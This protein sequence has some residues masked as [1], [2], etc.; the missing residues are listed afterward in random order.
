MMIHWYSLPPS[1]SFMVGVSFKKLNRSGAAA[2][3]RHAQELCTGVRLDLI[4]DVLPHAAGNGRD[5][6][7]VGPV[8]GDLNDLL[9]R[10]ALVRP[11]GRPNTDERIGIQV[12]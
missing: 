9:D 2:L 6:N 7:R 3:E 12:S 11:I 5:A 4:K 1:A 10:H 8:L